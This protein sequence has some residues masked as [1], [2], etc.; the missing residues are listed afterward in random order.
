MPCPKVEVTVRLMDCDQEPV[1]WQRQR[2]LPTGQMTTENVPY[3][4]TIVQDGT[5]SCRATFWNSLEVLAKLQTAVGKVVILTGQCALSKKGFDDLNSKCLSIDVTKGGAVNHDVKDDAAIPTSLILPADQYGNPLTTAPSTLGVGIPLSPPTTTSGSQG[6]IPA[7]PLLKREAT[8]EA[9]C[10]HRMDLPFC[11]RRPG[12]RHDEKCPLCAESVSATPI[13][14]MTGKY[15]PGM[16]P[17]PAEGG[18]KT[19]VPSMLARVLDLMGE[20]GKDEDDND[21]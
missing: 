1:F 10:C 7:S 6:S 11:V 13:C 9:P 8:G 19:E 18:K 3:F 17:K 15:H 4:R 20:K 2:R 14:G 5:G 16:D 12:V 21:A